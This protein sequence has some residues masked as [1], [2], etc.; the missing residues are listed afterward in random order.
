MNQLDSD[1][2]HKDLSMMLVANVTT[3]PD[4][5]KTLVANDARC[6]VRE[7]ILQKLTMLFLESEPEPD[8]IDLATDEPK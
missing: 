2:A 6:K 3:T 8:G 5:A 7:V 1:F 4:G